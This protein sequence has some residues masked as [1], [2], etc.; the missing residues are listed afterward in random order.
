MYSPLPLGRIPYTMTNKN[1]KSTGKSTK[2]T[3][4][5]KGRKMSKRLALYKSPATKRCTWLESI[6]N[7]FGCRPAHVPDEKTGLS[8]VVTSRYSYRAGISDST[9]TSTTHNNGWFIPPH[10]GAGLYQLNGAA[11]GSN[12]SDLNAAGSSRVNQVN[13]PNLDSITSGATEYCRS[14]MTS[15]GV[16]VTYEGTELQRAGRFVAGVI[17]VTNGAL[18]VASTGTFLSGLSTLT[19]SVTPSISNLYQSM[20]YRVESRIEDG[21]FEYHWT[22]NGAPNYQI[23]AGSSA[24]SYLPFTTTGG[25]AVPPPTFFNGPASQ[26]CVEGGQ[27]AMV[28]L[29]LGDTTA[30]ATGTSNVYSFDFIAHWEVIPENTYNAA[31]P[32]E[33]SPF[34]MAA[35][36]VVLNSIPAIPHGGNVSSAGTN[37]ETKKASATSTGFS[38]SGLKEVADTAL[39]VYRNPAVQLAMKAAFGF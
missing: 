19:G 15:M 3:K 22:P 20:V 7:P 2:S 5:K 24:T 14:R 1:G 37:V 17:P 9:G 11:G 27:F 18:T 33:A 34:D 26:G 13:W 31:Y 8:G 28:I 29:I 36:Q 38:M 4:P 12:L 16:R 39:A 21:V 23:T 10:L 32:L 35:L 25:T 6:T 30:T